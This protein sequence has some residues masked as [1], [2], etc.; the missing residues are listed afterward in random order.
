MVIDSPVSRRNR[1]DPETVERRLAPVRM[2]LLW[3]PLLPG[4]DRGHRIIPHR[5]DCD[6]RQPGEPPHRVGREDN[7]RIAV[8]EQAGGIKGSHARFQQIAED[9]VS[10][11]T[12]FCSRKVHPIMPPHKGG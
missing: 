7:R 6:T 10:V 5:S 1:G 11:L 12:M 8:R 4:K 2:S 3:L 9:L